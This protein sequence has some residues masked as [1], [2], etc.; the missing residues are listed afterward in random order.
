L[1]LLNNLTILVDGSG[2]IN[3]NNKNQQSGRVKVIAD[4][5]VFKYNAG[6]VLKSIPNYTDIFSKYFSNPIT[7]NDAVAEYYL[8]FFEEI[9]QDIDLEIENQYTLNINDT[10]D[11][12]DDSIQINSIE[13]DKDEFYYKI[14][15]WIL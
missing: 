14:K 4:E 15:G 9:N 11:V 10:I 3:V 12:Y 13:L 2:V 8:G 6:Y 5:H 7:L 1:L